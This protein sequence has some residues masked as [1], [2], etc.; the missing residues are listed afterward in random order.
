MTRISVFGKGRPDRQAFF[1]WIP[2]YLSL[3]LLPVSG[4]A[5]FIGL[6]AEIL[7]STVVTVV[8]WPP[9]FRLFTMG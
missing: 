8:K 6:V 2:L 3:W 5:L 1:F 9:S 7:E 4:S